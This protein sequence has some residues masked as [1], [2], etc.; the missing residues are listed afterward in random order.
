VARE[1]TV[2]TVSVEQP[3]LCTPVLQRGSQSG[4]MGCARLW[5]TPAAN[6]V[7]Y[8][9][10]SG[11]GA[12]AAGPEVGDEVLALKIKDYVPVTAVH[13]GWE[14]V[15]FGDALNMATG[16]G[17]NAPQREP[18]AFFADENTPKMNL[19]W[20]RKARTVQEKLDVSFSYGKYLWGPGAVFRYNSTHTFVLAAAMDSFLKRQAGP[21]A[22]LWDMVVSWWP[23]WRPG[24]DFTPLQCRWAFWRPVCERVHRL[25]RTAGASLACDAPA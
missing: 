3:S 11:R 5:V 25:A 15:T 19:Q 6:G 9:T 7:Q 14:R 10:L 8:A 1:E 22:H 21:Q 24:N 17:D 2:L 13:D 12:L 20:L 23:P 18:N 4:G 16:I